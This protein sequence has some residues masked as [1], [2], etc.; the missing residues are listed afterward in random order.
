MELKLN[1]IDAAVY[2]IIKEKKNINLDDL[3]ISLNPLNEDSIRRS[4]EVL[5]REGLIDENI[6][7]TKKYSL[8]KNGLLALKDGFI[9]ELFCNYLADKK[10]SVSELSKIEIPKIDKSELSLALGISKKKNLISIV[11]GIIFVDQDY[12]SKISIEK[13][14]LEK[15]N[16]NKTV[17]KEEIVDLLKRKDFIIEEEVLF[18]SYKLLEIVYYETI[19][20]KELY[21][22][23]DHLKSGDYKN[24]DYKE[25]DVEV[26]PKSK[27]IGRIHPLRVVMNQ[28]RDL[29]LEMGFK[30]M[31]GSYVQTSFWNMDAMFISQD[32]PARDSQDTF[33]L[34]ESGSLPFDEKL[35]ETVSEI[36]K[37]GGDTGSIG[38]QYDWSEKLARSLV[39]RT[40]TTAVTFKTFHNL[41]LEEKE[42]SKYFSIGKV[43]RN[44]TID[45][46]HLPEFHQAEGF[47]IGKDLGLADLLGFIKEFF[48]KLGIKEI[49]FKPTYNPY[50]EPS[51]EAYC[52]LEKEKKWVEI[53][54][55][56]IF[57]PETVFPFQINNT[58]IA[59]G[60]GVERLA[61]LLY[62]CDSLKE[63]HGDEPNLDWLRTYVLPRREL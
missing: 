20:D 7:V 62:G 55:A 5:K 50:T 27:E 14:I 45:S 12:L 19:Q 63:I 47:V 41:S 35:L 39:L 60:L 54:N 17:L 46:T 57:R 36:H 61:M 51:V 30:E 49:K 8:D 44:E 58:V 42:T 18:K 38:Y 52:Y 13:N 31:S 53:I 24:L 6:K 21:L 1:K 26:L 37:N 28:I 10:I 43:F 56:G 4:L 15:I 2:E 33:Y 9:E 29:Y 40:H 32:H 16:S 48:N 59:W 22:T 34:K 25:F 11:D 3:I 23:P